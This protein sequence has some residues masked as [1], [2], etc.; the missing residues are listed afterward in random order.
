MVVKP[1]EAVSRIEHAETLGALE[2]LH[3]YARNTDMP[4]DALAGATSILQVG[5]GACNFQ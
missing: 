5:S 3:E 1:P 2:L 4:P